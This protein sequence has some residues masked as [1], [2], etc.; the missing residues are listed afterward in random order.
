M[1]AR[2][3]RRAYNWSTDKLRNMI[4]IAFMMK[5]PLTTDG[6]MEICKASRQHIG[7][8]LRLMISSDEAKKT[9]SIP[10]FYS[11]KDEV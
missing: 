3:E 2:K 6:L 1:T 9:K 8:A 7:I 11:L 5:G 4:R 10:R